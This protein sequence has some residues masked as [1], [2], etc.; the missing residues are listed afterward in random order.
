MYPRL[1]L[2]CLFPLKE[3]LRLLT[4][5]P[6]FLSGWIT[7]ISHQSYLYSVWRTKPDEQE[8]GTLLTV[9]SP[10]LIRPSL[11]FHLYKSYFILLT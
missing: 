11:K 8:A 2:N 5:L 3:G 6:L 1:D 4:F 10:V 9:P 7:G